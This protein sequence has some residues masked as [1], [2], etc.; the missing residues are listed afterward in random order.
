MDKEKY[1]GFIA[2]F[3]IILVLTIPFYTTSV[4]ATIS[5]ISAKGSDG[6]EGFSKANDFLVFSAQA[7]IANDTITNDQVVLGSGLQFDKC[8]PSI[9]NGSECTLRFPSNGTE[10]F[11]SKSI[12]FTIKLFRDDKTLDDQKSGTFIVDNKPPQAKLTVPNT[13]FSPEE[14]VIINYEVADTACDDASCSGKCVGIKKIEFYALNGAFKQTI[15]SANITN[16]CSINSN[17]NIE[18]KKLNSGLN[19]VFAKATDKFNLVSPETS[20]TFTIGTNDTK[21]TTGDGSGPDILANSFVIARKGISLNTYG[22]RSVDVEVYVNIS[23]TNLDLNSVTADFSAL[24]SKQSSKNAKASCASVQSD[25]Y[26]CKWSIELNP[27]NGTQKA[28]IIN[29]SDTDGNK[30]SVSLTKILTLDDKGPVVQSLSTAAIQEGKIFVK[31]S[32]NTIIA[33]FDETTGLSADEVFLETANAKLGATSCNKDTNWVCTWTNANFGSSTKISIKSDTTDV[34]GNAV[35]EGKTVEVTLDSKPPVLR[36]INISPVGGLSDPFPGFFKI[37]DKFGVVANLTEENDVFAVADFSKF[38]SDA[39][40]VIGTCQRIQAN[41]HVC[42]WITEL[43]NLQATSFITFNFSDNAG[44]TL[45]FRQSLKTYGLENATTPDFWTNSVVCSPKIIDRQLGPLINQR[46]YCRVKLEPKSTSKSVSTVF[47]G[48][49]NCRADSN[50]SS[51]AS[52]LQ[53]FEAFNTEAGSTSPFLKITLKKDDFRINDLKLT[54]SFAIFSKTGT[55]TITKNPEVE[56][57]KI[58]LQFSNLPL[59]EVSERVQDKID[60]AKDDAE[61]IWKIIGTL[62]KLVFYAKKICQMF[63]VLYNIAATLYTV[64]IMLG[65]YADA[66]CSNPIT[67][68]TIC[69]VAFTGKVKSCLGQQTVR[70]TVQGGYT[71]FGH[72]FCKIVNCQYDFGGIIGQWQ[73]SLRT[74]INNLPLMSYLSNDPN[75]YMDPNKNLIVATAFVCLPGIIYGLDKYRQIKCLY[76]DCL[77][78]A[79]GKEGL[80][81]TACEDQKAYATCKYVTSEIFAILP[82]TAFIDHWL[83]VIKNSLSNPFS[84]LGAGISALCWATCPQ[85]PTWG[86]QA[87]EGIKLLSQMGAVVGEIKGI[88]DEG[89]KIRQDYCERL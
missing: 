58:N 33:V 9:N 66:T 46:L 86:Y 52:V 6:I 83:G 75:S 8:S 35:G 14:N 76:A 1:L 69:P 23:E 51:N 2:S 81:V 53:S 84:A 71:G 70:E 50:A 25:L 82:W 49:P 42:T 65:L 79:V 62:N 40:N 73:Q 20:V 17:I 26:T 24:N 4:Y 74:N 36:S 30:G 44:N 87:C 10:S 38:I 80:P 55:S 29:A 15:D 77:K 67:G 31:P 48:Q 37:G 41:E 64:A 54:C 27:R 60:D 7:S 16:E 39:S 28:I 78:N 11:E 21:G 61:G 12:P 47:I 85:S 88:I 3:L 19:S 43:I 57:V 13:K 18:S 68:L 72:E 63:G 22:P 32:G 34:L 89:F 45:I 5:K 56:N 59:G